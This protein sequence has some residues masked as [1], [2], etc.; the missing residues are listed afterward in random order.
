MGLSISVVVMNLTQFLRQTLPYISSDFLK[1]PAPSVFCLLVF[2]VVVSPA[3]LKHCGGSFHLVKCLS[4]SCQA[5]REIQSWIF[6][7]YQFCQI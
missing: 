6:L 4:L 5:C 7:W 1:K 2:V 3:E